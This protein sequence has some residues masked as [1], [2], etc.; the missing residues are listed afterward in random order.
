MRSGVVRCAGYDYPEWVTTSV[1]CT[2]ALSGC[3]GSHEFLVV[4]CYRDS[5]QQSPCPSGYKIAGQML[6]G[7]WAEAARV[8]RKERRS[9]CMYAGGDAVTTSA[10]GFDVANYAYC[11]RPG[12]ACCPRCP[13]NCGQ[14]FCDPT[15]ITTAPQG[16]QA[17]VLCVR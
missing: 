4:G 15:S 17:P 2:G 16:Y 12:D 11:W 13:T 7:Q 9:V 6:I 10:C 1:S 3:A 5:P 14:E 8:T